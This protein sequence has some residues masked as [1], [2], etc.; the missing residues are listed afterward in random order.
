MCISISLSSSH[1]FFFFL[2]LVV[3]TSVQSFHI[4]PPWHTHS[5][6]HSHYQ[7]QYQQRHSY[8]MRVVQMAMDNKVSFGERLDLKL[9]IPSSSSLSSSSTSTYEKPVLEAFL[10]NPALIIKQV[11]D[12]DKVAEV[13]KYML[14]CLLYI[15]IYF[16]SLSSFLLSFKRDT[17]FFVLLF[18]SLLLLLVGSR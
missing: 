13:H 17:F 10:A 7:Y 2:L 5:H 15:P 12:D 1:S 8:Y 3:A 14:L 6:S 11:W 9:P 4:N 18:S 16:A